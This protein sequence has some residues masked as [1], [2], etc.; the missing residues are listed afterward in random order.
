MYDVPSSALFGSFRGPLGSLWVSLGHE[1]G[2]LAGIRHISRPLEPK[3]RQAVELKRAIKGNKRAKDR[4]G[5][6]GQGTTYS[7]RRGV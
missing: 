1:D 7:V 5:Q 3:P 4:K 2:R 6:K